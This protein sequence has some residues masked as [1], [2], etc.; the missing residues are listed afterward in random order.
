MGRSGHLWQARFYSCP[1]AAGH[2]DTALRYVECNPLRARLV[3]EPWMYRWSS[4]A[5]HMAG[6]PEEGWLDAEIWRG[7]G[8][9]AGW[10]KL[11]AGPE[12]AP[13]VHMLR[14][15]TYAGRPFGGEAFVAEMESALHRRWQ[16]WPFE[17]T[18][19]DS[20]R[21]L[22]WGAAARAES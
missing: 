7:R 4:A 14:R 22:R 16:R 12:M 8:G 18:L 20:E 21:L 9:A 6:L 13:V 10:R 2:L 15:C 11:L 1:L 5:L 19:V 17:Q 3:D